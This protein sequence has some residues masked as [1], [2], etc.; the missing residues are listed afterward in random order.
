MFSVGAEHGVGGYC[1]QEQGGP[2]GGRGRENC[3]NFKKGRSGL[4]VVTRNGGARIGA[5]PVSCPWEL[6]DFE[7]EKKV[8]SREDC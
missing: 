8:P 4:E 1:S 7:R 6:W 3:K 5:S 2:E